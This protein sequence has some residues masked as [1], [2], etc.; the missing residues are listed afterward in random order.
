MEAELG[1]AAEP[2]LAAGIA[3]SHLA[4]PPLPG[5]PSMPR[6]ADTPAAMEAQAPTSAR[7]ASLPDEAAEQLGTAQLTADAALALEAPPEDTA[8]SAAPT[9]TSTSAVPMSTPASAAPTPTLGPSP[10]P[11]DGRG[12]GSSRAA[13]ARVLA[14]MTQRAPDRHA[15]KLIDRLQ[16]GCLDAAN[17]GK[18]LYECDMQLPASRRFSDSVARS[19]ASQAKGLEF[20]RFEWWSGREWK[21][22]PGRYCLLHDTRYDKYHMR[23]RVQWPESVS[24]RLPEGIQRV[25]SHMAHL[26][27]NQGDLAPVLQQLQEALGLQQALLLEASTAQARAEERAARAERRA[28]AAERRCLE[29]LRHCKHLGPLPP[30]GDTPLRLDS[31]ELEDAAAGDLHG[32]GSPRAGVGSGDEEVDVAWRDLTGA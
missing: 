14:E 3:E 28:A 4:M 6:R 22:M 26:E 15:E 27:M 29:A 24:P 30:A 25:T 11:T 20:S 5:S 1:L 16:Q 19:F 31:T 17:S 9:P 13:F 23:V 7:T 2:E 18:C 32:Q 10:A 8:T 21:V 12:G